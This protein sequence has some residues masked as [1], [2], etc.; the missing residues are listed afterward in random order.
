M[1]IPRQKFLATVRL[2][3]LGVS[4]SVSI[5]FLKMSDYECMNVAHFTNPH[6]SFAEKHAVPG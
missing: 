3:L 2:E 4:Y 6:L 1:V 5:E